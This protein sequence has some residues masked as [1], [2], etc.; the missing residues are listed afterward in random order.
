MEKSGG[1]KGEMAGET[2]A[3]SEGGDREPA[4]DRERAR[5][6][7]EGRDRFIA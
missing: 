3:A 1:G 7:C 2:P 6:E 4:G 5:V